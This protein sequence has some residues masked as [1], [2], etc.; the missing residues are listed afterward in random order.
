MK[1]SIFTAGI[2]TWKKVYL[3]VYKNMKESI[4]TAGIRAWKKVYL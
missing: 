4:F 1:E 3:Q 2:R